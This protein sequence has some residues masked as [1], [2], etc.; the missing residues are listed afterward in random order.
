MQRKILIVLGLIIMIAIIIGI[1]MYFKPH[2]NMSRQSADFSLSANE[3]V[4]DF[5]ADE[6]VANEK[7]VDKVIEVTGEIGSVDVTADK[8]TLI[9]NTENPVSGVICEMDDLS[10]HDSS[11]FVEGEKISLKCLCTGYL[12]DVAVRRCVVVNK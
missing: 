12:M 7:Y 2:E 5:E 3:L 9:L 11:L 6:A 1:S 10:D 4:Y 8:I